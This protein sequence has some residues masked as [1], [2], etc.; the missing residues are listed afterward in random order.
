MVLFIL[1]ILSILLYL[2]TF[3]SKTLKNKSVIKKYILINL[4]SFVLI[5]AIFLGFGL[6]FIVFLSMN[7][8]LGVFLDEFEKVF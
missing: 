1:V 6:I 7:E 3:Q 8:S 4:K 2:F 5:M